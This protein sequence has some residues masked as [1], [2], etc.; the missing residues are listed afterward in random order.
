MAGG[1]AGLHITLNFHPKTP[2][3]L[4]NS[5]KIHRYDENQQV[6]CHAL[7]EKE[8]IKVANDLAS[9]K[10]AIGRRILLKKPLWKSRF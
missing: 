10:Q 8:R 5:V 3:H 7:R 4:R 2:N 9:G 1:L 6:T